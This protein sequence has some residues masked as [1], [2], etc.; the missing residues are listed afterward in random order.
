MSITLIIVIFTS[1]TSIIAMSNAKM[2]GELIFWPAV[3]KSN[4]QYYRF[5]SYGLIHADYIHLSFNMLSLYSFGVFV[6]EHL[7][8]A[9]YFFDDKGKIFFLIMYA[10]ALIV[11]TIPDYIKYKDV[12]GY[13]ALG[14]SGAVSAVIFAG[15]IL[16]PNLPIRFMFIPFDIPGYIFGI[17]FLALSA[18]LAKKGTGNI[19]HVAHFFGAVFGVAFTVIAVKAFSTGHTDVLGEFMRAI[20]NR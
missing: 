14:A 16:Q 4:R 3:I 19:G 15:I 5:L 20:L 17:I 11:S 12:Y 10:G 8:S 2:K 1:V 6:E 18:Y 9:P 13:T 7:F